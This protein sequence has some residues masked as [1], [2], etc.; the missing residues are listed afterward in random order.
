M[1]EELMT[2]YRCALAE[3]LPMLRAKLKMTQEDL[4]KILNISRHTII[5]IENRSRTM[6]WTT[7]LALIFILE[8]FEETK[9]LVNILHLY[10]QEFDD[11]LFSDYNA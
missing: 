8:R 2:Q 10:P 9:L 11:A 5:G 1:N 6:P 7:Y 3:N 4:A